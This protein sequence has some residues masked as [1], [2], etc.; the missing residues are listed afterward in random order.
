MKIFS[1][2]NA[3]SNDTATPTLLFNFFLS[4]ASDELQLLALHHQQH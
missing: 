1:L 3:P 4:N 2:S